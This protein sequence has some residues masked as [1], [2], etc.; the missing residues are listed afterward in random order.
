MSSLLLVAVLGLAAPSRLVYEAPKEWK[1]VASTSSM[2][3]AQW[4]YGGKSE[5]VLFYF[6]EGQGG[7]V[8]ANLDRWYSQ[9]EQPGGGSTRDRAKVTKSKAGEL[10]ITRVTVEGTYTAPVRPGATERR[11]EPGYRMIAAVVEGPSG[12]WFIR[13]LGPAQEV[14]AG[15]A[16]FD[17]FL[18]K[19]QL[20]K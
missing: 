15:E 9:F 4:S 8:E 20:S 18:A 7:G 1:A 19:L 17:A 13:F 6:G 5:I 11:N 2:R 16:S 14:S 3:L 10:A 12:P